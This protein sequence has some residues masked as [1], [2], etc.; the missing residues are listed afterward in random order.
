METKTIH[1]RLFQGETHP[2]INEDGTRKRG[3][4]IGSNKLYADIDQ[5]SMFALM[6]VIVKCND[7]VKNYLNRGIVQHIQ[8]TGNRTFLHL[9]DSSIVEV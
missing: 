2:Q 7:T 3:R 5:S 8:I 4:P 6:P 1:I 9:K